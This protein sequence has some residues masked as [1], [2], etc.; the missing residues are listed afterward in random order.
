MQH[1]EIDK[2]V[3]ARVDR[4]TESKTLRMARLSRELIDKGIDIISL[5]LG[6]PDFDTPLYIQEA[7]IAAMHNGF[8]HYPPVAGYPDLRRAIAQRYHETYGMDLG[9]ANTLV[10]TGAKHSLANLVLALV[11]H[12]DEVL[13]PAPYW[14]TYPEQVALAGG[15]V[16]T[17]YA[18]VEQDYKMRPEQ[19]R[20]ALTQDT[21]LLIFSSPSNPTGSVYS[22]EELAAMAHVIRDFPNLVV[23]SD[24]IYEKINFT[25]QHH[26]LAAHADLHH[27]L[28]IVNGVSK[29]YA[30]TGWR[31]GYLVAPTWIVQ[32]CEKVQGQL[33]SATNSI[34]MK[35]TLAAITQEDGSVQ[36]MVQEFKKRRDF[37]YQALKQVP[38]IQLNLPDGAFYLFADVASYYGKQAHGQLI[39]NSEDLVMYLLDQA[40]VAVVEGDAFGAPRCIR[41][42]YATHINVLKEAAARLVSAFHH[43][44]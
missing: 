32:A 13:I 27:R 12:G 23:V 2:R 5:S 9:P 37:M 21:R 22:Q 36:H 4:L 19:L 7:A 15:K 20:Q 26:S 33:T 11:D 30:M 38:G 17:V 35:A 18:G 6:E 41:L 10:S 43:L 39:N 8:T 34:A 44:R 25:G 24:E 28:V 16:R 31:I 1:M 42:S 29:G 40:H 3:A 14:V